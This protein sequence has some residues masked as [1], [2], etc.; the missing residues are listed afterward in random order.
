[1]KLTPRLQAVADLAEGAVSLADIGTDHGFIPAYF[2]LKGIPGPVA[3][4]DVGK[5]PLSSASLTVAQ[6][7]LEGKVELILSDGLAGLED[8]YDTIVIA[9]MGGDL[10]SRILRSSPWPLGG[11]RLVLQPQSRTD[12]VFETLRDL[13]FEARAG[14]IAR[15]GRRLYTAFLAGTGSGES[16][17]G[18]ALPGLDVLRA[19]P[20]FPAWC[21]ELE[22]K[23]LRSLEGL[24]RSARPDRQRETELVRILQEVRDAA[25][26]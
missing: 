25:G 22:K 13:G 5:G 7:G 26:S 17:Q 1:M 8:K 4:C 21:R 19:D 16:A 24:R 2:A 11:K 15:E 12:R 23:T 9:G 18:P 3:A 6:L 20:L 10:M 14:K